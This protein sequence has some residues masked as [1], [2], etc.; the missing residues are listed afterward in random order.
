MSLKVSISRSEQLEYYYSQG[1]IHYTTLTVFACTQDCTEMSE[2]CSYCG[3]GPYRNVN[4]HYRYC[5]KYKS[6]TP[7]ANL[8][9]KR[10]ERGDEDPVIHNAAKSVRFEV[11]SVPES[12]SGGISVPNRLGAEVCIVN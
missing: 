8:A 5:S 7:L 12:Q 1:F 4:K 2:I 10:K 11:N 9:K 6:Y 3:G